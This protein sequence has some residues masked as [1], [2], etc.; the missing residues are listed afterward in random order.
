MELGRQRPWKLS[1]FDKIGAYSKAPLTA[2]VKDSTFGTASLKDFANI[3]ALQPS[4]LYQP[5]AANGYS[6][7]GIGEV[8]KTPKSKI[9]FTPNP[10]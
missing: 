9:G 5:N 3:A 2:A 10:W 8:I 6:G 7:S 4:D 1:A